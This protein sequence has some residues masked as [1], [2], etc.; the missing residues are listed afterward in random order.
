ML[1]KEFRIKNY[2]SF[3]DSDSVELGSGFNIIL[4]QNN[5]GK[6]ALLEA[7]RLKFQSK[8]HRS[9]SVLPTP[10]S[11]INPNSTVEVSLSINGEELKDAHINGGYSRLMILKPSEKS[12]LKV[13]AL[14]YLHQLW[15]QDEVIIQL[16]F[17]ATGMPVLIGTNLYDTCMVNNQADQLPYFMFSQ[18]KETQ[19]FQYGGHTTANREHDSFVSV[20]LQLRDRVYAFKAERM[21]VSS[22]DFGSNAVLN[23][24]ASNLPEVLHVLQTRNPRRFRKLNEYLRRI[25]PVVYEVSIRPGPNDTQQEIV[26][27]TTN[28]ETER[29]DLVIEL[30]ESGTG[31]GQA[32]AILY[33]VLT[34][35]YPRTIII[36]EPNSFLHPTAVR[37]LI[38]ILQEFNQHQYIIST[39][40]PEVISVSNPTSILMVS[41]EESMSVISQIDL[42]DIDDL[43]R[44]LGEIGSKFSDLLGPECVLWVEG[45]TEEKCFGEILKSIHK[46]VATDVAIRAVRATGDF[47]NKKLP[48]TL[49]WDVYEKISSVSAVLPSHIA[50]EFDREGRTTKQM[51]DL[52]KRSG[53]KIS[54]L[55]RKTFENY[56]I[57]AEALSSLMSTMPAFDGASEL[58]RKIN[59]W[60]MSNGERFISGDIADKPL[61][62]QWLKNVDGAKCLQEL[63]SCLSESKEEY[64]KTTH[65][66]WLTCW[67]LENQPDALGELTN[68]VKTI[69]RS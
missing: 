4:G 45:P 67:L 34:S 41:L 24:D 6:T 39:H 49:I 38:E 52:E 36:D 15:Q 20:G 42:D 51:Q 66:E 19:D 47:E 23:T 69:T 60:I 11:P 30:S 16:E 59:E 57:H 22:C 56:L 58:E 12:Y 48:D 53:G 10:R 40:S 5:S 27:W 64:K 68:F 65:G 8:P 37:H 21:N 14:D 55:P 50:F 33:V 31:I 32:L 29:E 26:V 13:Q 1:I 61:S 46:G 35:E 43:R 62:D 25:F 63:V 9:V 3:L 2:K 54:F 28:P 18:N 7:L 17:K 44:A